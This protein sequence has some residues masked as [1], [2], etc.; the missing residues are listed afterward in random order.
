[1]PKG[2]QRQ[3]RPAD[4]VANAI[5]VANIL[6]GEI[7]EDMETESLHNNCVCACR[8]ARQIDGANR[9]VH[10]PSDRRPRGGYGNARVKE[11]TADRVP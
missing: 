10:G 1:M 11:I 4:T 5:R 6:T 7:E 9:L 8:L 2:P 3:K